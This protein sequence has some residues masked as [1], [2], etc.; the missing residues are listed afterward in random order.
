MKM[1]IERPVAD[2]NQS[3]SVLNGKHAQGE[4]KRPGRGFANGRTWLQLPP[5]RCALKHEPGWK[6]LH[7]EKAGAE[8]IFL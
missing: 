4:A 7:Q 3:V 5:F 2:K 8:E 6:E 1:T